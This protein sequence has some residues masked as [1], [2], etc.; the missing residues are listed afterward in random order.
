M[1]KHTLYKHCKIDRTWR[2]DLPH[3]EAM[4]TLHLG[5]LI[6][7]ELSSTWELSTCHTGPAEGT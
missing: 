7:P 1:A 3:P 6:A 4:L 2:R 5:A